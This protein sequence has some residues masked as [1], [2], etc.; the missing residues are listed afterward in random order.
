MGIVKTASTATPIAAAARNGS[1]TSAACAVTPTAVTSTDIIDIVAISPVV[2]ILTVA[3]SV[4]NTATT[5][6][7]TIV[8]T[9]K[10]TS[11]TTITSTVVATTSTSTITSTASVT[12]LS[13]FLSFIIE[14]VTDIT[15]L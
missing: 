2:F 10:N 7:A 15:L 4:T 14:T 3:Y 5:T 13:G 6:T 12:A 8:N 9:D 11:T 1:L